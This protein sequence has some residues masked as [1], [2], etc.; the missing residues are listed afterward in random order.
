MAKKFLVY[1]L[2]VDDDPHEWQG[3]VM[4]SITGRR[5]GL[6]W[7][8]LL[9]ALVS[10]WIPAVTA[11]PS[12]ALTGHGG[13]SVLVIAH[14]GASGYLPEHTLAA[15]EAA[16]GMGADFIEPDVVMTKDGVLVARHEV[17]ITETTDVARHPEFSARRTMKLIDGLAEEG[18]FVDDF[19]LQELKTLRA[20]QRL[21]FRSSR[22]DGRFT[23]P[24]LEE[25]I[26]LVQH[27]GRRVGLY[28]ELK[29]PSYFL[30]HGLPVDQALLEVLARH[31]YREARDPVFIQCFEVGLL[32]ALHQR[33]ML[34][35]IQLVDA[36]GVK[37]DGTIIPTR[38][39]DFVL[40]G[41][42]RTT[43]DLLTPAGLA[44]MAGYAA[45]IGPYKRYV[46]S[47]RGTDGDGDGQND[48]INH[49]AMVDEADTV[50]MPP[51]TLVG[52]AHRAGLLVHVWT[53]RSEGRYLPAD[54]GGNPLNE[55]LQFLE[56]GV[57]GFFADY[58]DQA[59]SARLIWQQLAD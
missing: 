17:N 43:A 45:G 23:I 32:K 49:D 13:R 33:T 36:L 50:T 16:I 55:Y 7:I 19:T 5:Q 12:H 4:G 59:H 6:R 34:R 52:D 29:H 15:Y 31:G 46:I 47:A 22:F 21:A 10:P 37:P 27:T 3:N 9:A 41:D 56:L 20:R 35:L 38:P 48:D 2:Q 40:S 53:M 26:A 8:A 58:P 24:T 11:A 1:W 57:D 39:Y 51:T 25:I 44:E 28:I 18:W 42:H 54:Y 30:G 14:R